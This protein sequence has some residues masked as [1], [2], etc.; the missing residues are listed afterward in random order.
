[1]EHQI[2]TEITD[3]LVPAIKRGDM[4]AAIKIYRDYANCDLAEAKRVCEN[5][6]KGLNFLDTGAVA[7]NTFVNTSSFTLTVNGVRIPDEAAAK[8]RAALQ[9]GNRHGAIEILR[10]T[11]NM[12]LASA[13][14]AVAAMEKLHLRMGAGQQQDIQPAPL[15][16]T[17][18][19]KKINPWTLLLIVGFLA[20]AVWWLLSRH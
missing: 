7:A 2:P 5:L 12:D 11:C 4:I 19:S 20:C 17:G 9:S 10:E 3:Q 6:Q 8:A 14:T 13:K 1:M 16:R 18:G 15:T